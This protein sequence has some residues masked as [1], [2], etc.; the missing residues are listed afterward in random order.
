[1]LLLCLS[2]SAAHA[3]DLCAQGR[4]HRGKVLDLDVANADLPEVLRLLADTA[5]INLVVGPT[6]TGRVTLKLKHVAWDA[7]ACTIAGLHHLRM[8]VEDNIL[9]VM[10]IK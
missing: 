5:N 9:L 7:V 1:M 8:T 2:G 4:L 10:P 6:V 3:G